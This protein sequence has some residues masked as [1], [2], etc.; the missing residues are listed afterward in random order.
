MIEKLRF[1]H[2]TIAVPQQPK[3]RRWLLMRLMLSPRLAVKG[4]FLS[5][6]SSQ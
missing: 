1:V 3:P 6:R 4:Y 2:D 5:Y